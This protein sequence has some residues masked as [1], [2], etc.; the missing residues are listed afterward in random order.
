MCSGWHGLITHHGGAGGG[1][2]T[3]DSGGCA[4]QG[5]GSKAAGAG[6]HG[7]VQPCA[8]PS[9][10][11]SGTPHREIRDSGRQDWRPGG[12]RRQGHQGHPAI[13]RLCRPGQTIFSPCMTLSSHQR[14][15]VQRGHRIIEQ[16]L[17]PATAPLLLHDTRS[18][19][20]SGSHCLSCNT[21]RSLEV[22]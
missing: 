11:L 15:F 19:Q 10:V 4:G 9:H 17:K 8:G 6:S 1:H 2:H 18:R 22:C 14:L 7:G 21:C 12:T 5:T 20:P 16:H 13:L 3:G